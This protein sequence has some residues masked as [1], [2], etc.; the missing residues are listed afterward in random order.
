MMS[1][2]KLITPYALFIYGHTA[3]IIV[4]GDGW[5]H[6]TLLSPRWLLAYP[7]LFAFPYYAYTELPL[8]LFSRLKSLPLLLPLP[9]PAKYA[10]DPDAAMKLICQLPTLFVY[11]QRLLVAERAT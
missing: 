10:I 4:I 7:L 5:L 3:I 8:P 11:G 2:Q 6:I 1:C 9:L